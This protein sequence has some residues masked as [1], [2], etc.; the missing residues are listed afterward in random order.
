MTR[1]ETAVAFFSGGNNCAQAVFAA[2]KDLTHINRETSFKIAYALGG[3]MGR[4][5]SVC[6]AFSGAL[7]VI[8]SLAQSNTPDNA[9]KE[10]I[11][12]LTREFSGKFNEKYKTN[13]CG[14]ILGVNI[15]VQEQRDKAKEM[16]LFESIC[17]EAVR[18]AVEI[19]E[20]LL[21]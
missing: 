2:F 9:E 15:S 14:D 16:G 20:E 18:T 10:R 13:I 6:G 21:K 3:G 1:S 8:G 7:L 17:P 19:L 5:N 11:Y 4:T 12:A